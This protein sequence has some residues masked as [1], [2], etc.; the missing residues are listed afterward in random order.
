MTHVER[1]ARFRLSAP[2]D[3]VFPFFTP[4]GER[5][6]VA[7]WA[8]EWLHPAEGELA[9]GAVFRTRH[10]GEETLWA[11]LDWEPEAARVRYA[12]VTPGSRFGFVEVRCRAGAPGETEV[13]VSYALTAL[14]QDGEAR[15]AGLTEAAFAATMEEWRARIAPLL[16]GASS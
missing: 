9:A 13:S 11:C 12:R 14:E 4:E 2:V 7:G 16:A 6:W 5:R 15:L 1:Q 3:E 10:D 8:P